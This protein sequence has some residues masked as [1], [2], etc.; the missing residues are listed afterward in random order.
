MVYTLLDL[1]GMG[2]TVKISHQLSRMNPVCAA[3][4]SLYSLQQLLEARLWFDRDHRGKWLEE[5]IQKR[6]A[7]VAELST[8]KGSAGN[9]GYRRYRLY[10]LMVGILFLALSSGPFVAVKFL[11]TIRVFNDINGDY[12]FLTGLWAVLTLPFAALAYLIGGIVDAERTV[13]WFK[14]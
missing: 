4:F 3:D 8:R 11:E 2:I 5:E 12:A 13:R 14:L 6:C 1:D 7:P 10:G 9:G